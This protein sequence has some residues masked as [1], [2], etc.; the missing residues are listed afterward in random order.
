MYN[1]YRAKAHIPVTK[2]SYIRYGFQTKE[3]VACAED[4]SS[5]GPVRKFG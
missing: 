5:S 3:I 4:E 2:Q 1:I